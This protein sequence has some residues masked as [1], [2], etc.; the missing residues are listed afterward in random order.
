MNPPRVLLSLLAGCAALGAAAPAACALTDYP[1]RVLVRTEGGEKRLIAHNAGPSPVTVRVAAGDDSRASGMPWPRTVV[2]KPRARIA[3]GALK[4][5]GPATLTYSYYLGRIDAAIDPQVCYRL[6][7]P[8][9]LAFRVTQAYGG[10]LTSHDDA[11]N[12]HAVDF[13]MP[14]GTPV[15]AARGGVVI[16]VT[17]TYRAGGLDR[18]FLRRAN[19]ITIVHDDGTIAEYA[20]LAHRA[21]LVQTGQRVLR[22][23]RIAASGNTGYSSAPH[24]H[25]GVSK[26]ALVD[27]RIRPISVPFS[28][29]GETAT[30]AYAPA[31]GMTAVAHAGP[32]LGGAES[33]APVGRAR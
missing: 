7:Y 27:G 33:P 2:V 16:D 17:L 6:P 26:P 8:D 9:G 4:A 11:E 13:D 15:V 18:A 29:C 10:R 21:P 19:K 1:F 23:T 28:F 14:E 30:A 5:S 24:L 22:G 3:L 25:F 31:P 12:R 32:T 20:H